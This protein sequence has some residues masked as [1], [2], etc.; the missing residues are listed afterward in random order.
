MIRNTLPRSAYN[1]WTEI[2]LNALRHNLALI[3]A[4]CSPDVQVMGVVKANA[5][6]HNVSL[7]APTLYAQ[8]VRHFGIATIAEGLYLKERVPPDAQIL[9]LG[10]L[11]RL[12]YEQALTADLAFMIHSVTHIPLINDLGECLGK[13]ARVH[14]KVDTGMGRVGIRPEDFHEALAALLAAP[15]IELVGICSH[16]ATSDRANCPHVQAQL[17][18]FAE[19]H[20]AYHAHPQAQQGLL[21]HIANSDAIFAYPEAHYN[22]VRPGISLYG[23][24]SHGAPLQPVLAL[25]GQM[26]QIHALPAG[27]S[28]GYGRTFTTPQDSVIAVLPIGYADGLNRLLSNRM[29]VLIQGQP[30]PIVG[31]ISMDQCL[32]DVTLQDQDQRVTLETPVT[33]LGR[34]GEAAISAE[35]W[36]RCSDTIAYEVL[37]SLGT[38]IPRYPV[39]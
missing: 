3:Q 10:A 20:A 34:D 12:Q 26:T 37:T 29:H 9:V 4:A 24:G 27:T 15:W 2:D 16:L 5:Y 23:Y 11:S 28:L 30:A 21:F 8:G 33:L 19:L 39:S 22:L 18:L 38:R 13:P 17:A 36:A 35:D 7:V 14:L 1:K 32:I 6:G 31:R 25:K